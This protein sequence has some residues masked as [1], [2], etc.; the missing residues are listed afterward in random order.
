MK[1]ISYQII[2]EYIITN[3]RFKN[4]YQYSDHLK[5]FKKSIWKGLYL[6]FFKYLVYVREKSLDTRSKK[7]RSVFFY[8]ESTKQ[9]P[10][11]HSNYPVLYK[12]ITYCDQLIEVSGFWLVNRITAKH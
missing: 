5:S 6:L 2:H 7:S 10:L 12:W 9:M 3:E 8:S 1:C 11:N 4:G